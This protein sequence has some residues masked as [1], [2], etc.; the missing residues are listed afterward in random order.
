MYLPAVANLSNSYI[1]TANIIAGKIEMLVKSTR[2]YPYF[3][4]KGK[5][6]RSQSRDKILVDFTSISIVLAMMLAN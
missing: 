2:F 6:N 4:R 3:G 1:V 5:C